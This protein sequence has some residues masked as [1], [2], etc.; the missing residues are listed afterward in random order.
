MILIRDGKMGPVPLVDVLC[1]MPGLGI[2]PNEV[3]SVAI[4][5]CAA[6]GWGVAKPRHFGA[7]LHALHVLNLKPG[8]AWLRHLLLSSYRC[9]DQFGVED[10]LS[11]VSGLALTKVRLLGAVFYAFVDTMTDC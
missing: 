6:R 7:M 10:S 8:A 2:K 9:W 11:L 3:I 1:A 4:L 5:D